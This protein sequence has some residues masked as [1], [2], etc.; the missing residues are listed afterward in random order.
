MSLCRSARLEGGQ[1]IIKATIKEFCLKLTR[2]VELWMTMENIR[3]QKLRGWYILYPKQFVRSFVRTT[4]QGLKGQSTAEQK[5][6]RRR[7]EA[8]R[9]IELN[10]GRQ[11]ET[12]FPSQCSSVCLLNLKYF[13][14]FW[15]TYTHQ[16]VWGGR[17]NKQTNRILGDS[18]L[19]GAVRN[20]IA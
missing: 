12:E 5:A 20:R 6:G 1:I 7:G 9:S 10:T 18:I 13:C 17:I 15:C 14:S 8:T 19:K 16:G 4:R 11:Y 2:I 3:G